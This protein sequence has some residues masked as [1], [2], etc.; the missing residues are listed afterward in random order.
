MKNTKIAKAPEAITHHN[1]AMWLAAGP[2]GSSVESGAVQPVS[3]TG[4]N[5][6]TQEKWKKNR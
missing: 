3:A 4:V 2:A 1:V 6:M 5:G